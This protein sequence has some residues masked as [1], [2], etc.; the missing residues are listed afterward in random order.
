MKKKPWFLPPEKTENALL[1][2]L[3]V[4]GS[5]GQKLFCKASSRSFREEQTN[6]ERRPDSAMYTHNSS[7][8]CISKKNY[9]VLEIAAELEK[10]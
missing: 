1:E 5:G 4:L 2:P 3:V 6:A 10:H 7:L 8:R 9:C